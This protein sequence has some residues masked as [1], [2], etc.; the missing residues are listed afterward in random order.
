MILQRLMRRVL[1]SPPGRRPGLRAG[2]AGLV[3]LSFS[4]VLLAPPSAADTGDEKRAADAQVADL[5]EQLSE[6]SAELAQAYT[7]LT[8][9]QA[10]LPAARARLASAQSAARAA[11]KHNAE[12]AAALAVARANAARAEEAVARN[13]ATRDQTQRTL[14]A[15]AA[16]LFQGG[17]V[18]QLSVALGATSAD[19]FA[20]RLVLADTVTAMTNQALNDLAAAKADGDANGAY[21]AAVQVEVTDLKRQAENALA[22]AEASRNEAQAASSALDALVAQQSGYAASVE[23]QR[24]NEAS[25]LAEAQAEQQRLQALLIEQARIAREREAA[26][27][28][29]EAA[30]QKAAEEAARKNGTAVPPPPVAQPDQASGFLSRPITGGRTSSEFGMRFHPIFQV[31]RLHTGL[32]FANGC[33][34][35][36]YAAAP[37]TIIRAGWAGGRGNQIVIDHG[38]RRGVDLATTYNHLTSFV[39]RS[40]T[41][42]R[43]QLI[44]YTGTTGNSTGCHLHFETLE[45]GQFVNPR[46]WL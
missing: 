33:S 12:V 45:D 26:R 23:A 14:D 13:T 1:T 9:T 31:W 35:P 21:L 42:S 18:G 16:D 30:A 37:G 22:A 4:A 36:V 32:D 17:S 46:S 7:A 11:A 25:Q 39:Q 29:A 6:T 40:G 10:Q 24:A 38:I 41:V 20:T 5:E 43:G 15:F 27:K 3:V 34:S 44:G 2:A 8:Q 28:A 19:D